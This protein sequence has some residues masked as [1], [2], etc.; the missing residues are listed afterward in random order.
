MIKGGKLVLSQGL[1]KKEGDMVAMHRLEQPCYTLTFS[2]QFPVAKQYFVSIFVVVHFFNI[3][4]VN[5]CVYMRIIVLESKCACICGI[6]I[7]NAEEDRDQ[8]W[9][10][11]QELSTLFFVNGSLRELGRTLRLGFHAWAPELQSIAY[12][13][14]NMN[15]DGFSKGQIK[16]SLLVKAQ[17]VTAMSPYL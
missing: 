9:V 12:Q 2:D 7:A 15:M 14:W 10:M 17:E 16:L 11:L 3:S 6:V 13:I 5:L 1:K 8:P 4:C